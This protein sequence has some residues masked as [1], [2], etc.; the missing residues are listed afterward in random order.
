M[1]AKLRNFLLSLDIGKHN[2]LETFAIK[3]NIVSE[4]SKDFLNDILVVS[5]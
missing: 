5:D 1:K 4:M 3:R 2:T